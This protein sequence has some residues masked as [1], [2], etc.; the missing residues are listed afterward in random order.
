MAKF[1]ASQLKNAIF[2][3]CK[4][5]GV[6][7]GDCSD[8]LF[9]VSFDSCILDYT[10]FAGKKLVKTLFKNSS[11]KN[12]DLSECD[13]TASVFLNCDLDSAVFNKTILKEA[14]FRT[15]INFNIDPENNN[16][17]KAKFSLNG[18]AGLLYK[19]NLTID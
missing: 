2:S 18:L 7:F 16:I 11:L 5:L 19:Y 12:A 17:R 13:L 1:A 8:S 4:I 6:N 3:R 10:S 9:S 14:D 15:A